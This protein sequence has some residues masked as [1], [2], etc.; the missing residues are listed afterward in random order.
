MTNDADAVSVEGAQTG[1]GE[2]AGGPSSACPPPLRTARPP[3][4]AAPR[5]PR[6]NTTE[7]DPIDMSHYLESSDRMPLCDVLE[8]MQE[9]ITDG[10]T[11]YFGVPTQKNPLDFWVY[12]ELLTARPPD[13]IVEIGN[14]FGGSALALAHL[15]D[16][17]GKGRIIAIDIDH[18]LLHAAAKA[19]PRIQFMEGDACALADQVKDRIPTGADVLVIEDSSHTYRNT[20]DVLRAYSPLT[21]PGGYFIVED[22]ICHHGLDLGPDPGPFEAVE[23]FVA[24]NQNFEIDRSMESFLITWNPKGFLRR[25]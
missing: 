2:W 7:S 17:V 15:C 19:H 23:D 24:E 14:K 21:L 11:T 4:R 6:R 5:A 13:V 10:R 18:A 8:I 12:Q 1:I 3:S 16:L 9:R 22:S 20:L 25:K